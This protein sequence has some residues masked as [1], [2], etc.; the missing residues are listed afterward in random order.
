MGEQKEKKISAY[1]KNNNTG[2]AG[3]IN[4]KFAGEK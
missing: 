4:K 1:C 2:T 3:N